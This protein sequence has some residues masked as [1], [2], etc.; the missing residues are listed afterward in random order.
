MHI[1]VAIPA[2]TLQ[3]QY[4]IRCARLRDVSMSHLINR[5]IDRIGQ[6]QLVEAVLDDAG[7]DRSKHAHRFKEV[8]E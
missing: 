3:G 5:L 7:E 6:D 1:N 8:V 4:L 2:S